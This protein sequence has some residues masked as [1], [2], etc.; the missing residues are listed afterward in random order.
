MS[1]NYLQPHVRE[2]EP[3]SVLVV[4]AGAPLGRLR[5]K[6]GAGVVA[7]EGE[8]ERGSDPVAVTGGDLD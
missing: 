7:A 5:R 3:D 1:F 8:A 6:E 4:P 2:D